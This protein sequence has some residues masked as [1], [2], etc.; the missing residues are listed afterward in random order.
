MSIPINHHYVSQY[1]VRLFFNEQEKKIYCY[2]KVY[3]KHHYKT[4]TKSLFSEDYANTRMSNAGMDHQ[5]LEEQLNLFF[6]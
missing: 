6:E 2:D 4:T 5:E 3:D 1:H